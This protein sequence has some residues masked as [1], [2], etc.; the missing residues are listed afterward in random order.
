MPVYDVFARERLAVA[1][2][3]VGFTAGTYA[4]SGSNAADVAYLQVLT[5]DIYWVIGTAADPSSSV[6]EIAHPEDRITLT[7][8]NDIRNF[9]AIRVGGT[10]GAIEAQFAKGG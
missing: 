10:S 1:A 4:P 9:R 3:A 7:G 8:E 2:T 6:G 5:A